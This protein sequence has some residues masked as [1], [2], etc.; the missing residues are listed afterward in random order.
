MLIE[1]VLLVVVLLAV[2]CDCSSTSLAL[3]H[4]QPNKQSDDNKQ[5]YCT[6]CCSSGDGADVRFLRA[7]CR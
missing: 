5:K 1:M 6:T 4:A 2:S 7:C 3:L